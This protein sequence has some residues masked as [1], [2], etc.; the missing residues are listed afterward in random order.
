MAGRQQLRVRRDV[1]LG[2]ALLAAIALAAPSHEASHHDAGCSLC[3]IAAAG[4]VA[5]APS[6]VA[7]HWTELERLTPA[8]E[9]L[10]FSDRAHRQGARAPPLQ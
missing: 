1:L 6:E 9:K 8:D 5:A 2:I 7:A 10:A 3:T 4:F